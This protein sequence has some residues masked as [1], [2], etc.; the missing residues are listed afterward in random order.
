MAWAGD[1]APG[2]AAPGDAALPTGDDP[3]PQAKAEVIILHGTNSGEGIDPKIGDLPQLK[4]P[5]F[6][7]YDSY[8]LLEKADQ[9]L[10]ADET[11]SR[12]LPNDGKLELTL[13]DVQQGKKGKRYSLE[14]AIKDAKG[15]DLLPSVKWT[16]RKGEY[17]FLAGP[18][19]KKGILVIGIRIA[20]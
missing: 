13:Q 16:T 2:R 17:V 10:T 12:K 18:K 15:K 8:K 1:V 6:S 7:A 19:Y 5:P 11:A 9:E 3:A 20:K 4:E 14:A